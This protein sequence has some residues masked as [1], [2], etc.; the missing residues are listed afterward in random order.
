MKYLYTFFILF[1]FVLNAQ[2]KRIRPIAVSIKAGFI[3]FNIG[4][5]TA[6]SFHINKTN[7]IGLEANFV[8]SEPQIKKPSSGG[9][10]PILPF[11][12]YTE[13]S[14]NFMVKYTYFLPSEKPSYFQFGLN[15]GLGMTQLDKII[16]Y[17]ENSTGGFLSFTSYDKIVRRI[18]E[19][20]YQMGLQLIK[21]KKTFSYFGS[22]DLQLSGHK[23][24]LLFKT[25]L[26][27][28]I[29]KKGK[30]HLFYKN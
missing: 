8:Y 17:E 3:P 26:Q 14:Q 2:E 13:Y 10:G 16:G 7:A 19:T 12:G 5:V 18:S 11:S 29:F 15:A 25:G 23:A 28:N 27:I 9:F 1:S 22:L 24:L 4:S 20:T 21:R 6:A 30:S